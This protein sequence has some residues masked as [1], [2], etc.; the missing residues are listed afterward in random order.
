MR[1]TLAVMI[2]LLIVACAWGQSRR[3]I[4]PVTTAATTTQSINETRN[5]TA[6]INAKIRERSTL[7]IDDDGRHVYTDTIT[8]DQ[9]IDSTIISKVPKM[10]YP[11]FHSASVSVNIWDP[12]MR[13][14]GQKYGLVDFTAELNLHNRYIPVFEA[15]I[16]TAS[17]R[18]DYRSYWYRSPVNPYFKIGGNYNFLFNSNPDYLL[19]FAFRYGFSN[20][21]YSVEDV[22]TGSDYWGDHGT[23]SVPSQRVSAGWLEL[24]IGLRVKIWGPISAG[25]TV[26]FH[27]M[28]HTSRAT[29]GEPW[30]IPGFGTKNSP[31]SASISISYTIPLKHLN[32]EKPADVI[33]SEGAGTTLGTLPP[34]TEPNIE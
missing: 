7:H 8:G 16:G 2:L 11:L 3:K 17:Y 34:M 32:K 27:S 6:R 19:F 26:K 21:S 30:Y 24:G 10:E 9:W 28:V 22:K 15:G 5:D 13:A 18:P 33:P 14:F 4:N 23:M 29:Y 31:L 12:L 20:F 25:W 1:K